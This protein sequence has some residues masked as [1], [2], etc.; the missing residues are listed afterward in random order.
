MAEGE[1]TFDGM[2]DLQNSLSNVKGM[3]KYARK[4]FDKEGK[5]GRRA[6]GRDLIGDRDHA[7]A[8]GRKI[9]ADGAELDQDMEF[10]RRLLK[11]EVVFG[12]TL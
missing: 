5:V 2:V 6:I 11:H 1:E 4:H 8:L 7:K 10:M 3:G 12:S 9:A